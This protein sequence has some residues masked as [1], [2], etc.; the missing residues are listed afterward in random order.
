MLEGIELKVVRP[1]YATGSFKHTLAKKRQLAIAACRARVDRVQ[2]EGSINAGL[3]RKWGLRN[4]IVDVHGLTY[5]EVAI[6]HGQFY[7]RDPPVLAYFVE[8]Q[9]ARFASTVVVVSDTM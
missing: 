8:M 6:S 2:V 4:Y 5:A 9:G 7:W 1:S 3:F